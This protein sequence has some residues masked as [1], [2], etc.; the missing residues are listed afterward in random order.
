MESDDVAGLSTA[1]CHAT[2]AYYIPPVFNARE[3][4]FGADVIAAARAAKLPRFVYH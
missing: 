3:E 1:L 4:I 2:G